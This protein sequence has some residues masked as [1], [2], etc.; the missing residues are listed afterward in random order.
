M[1]DWNDKVIAEFRE[2]AGR[3]GG[4]LEGAPLLLLTR[5][6][7]ARCVNFLAVYQEWDESH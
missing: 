4:S 3:V 6:D 7:S 2:N 1:S 5:A